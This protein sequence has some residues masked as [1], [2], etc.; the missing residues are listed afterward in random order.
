MYCQ[1]CP[2]HAPLRDQTQITVHCRKQVVLAMQ[3]LTDE[4]NDGL[5]P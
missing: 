3:L 2:H 4:M 5:T 1:K